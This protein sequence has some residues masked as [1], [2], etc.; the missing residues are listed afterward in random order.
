MLLM[1][2][3]ELAIKR[4]SKMTQ[5]V[6]VSCLIKFNLQDLDGKRKEPTPKGS[7]TSKYAVN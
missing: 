1:L 3:K 7:L 6:K 5:C 2:S 4:A